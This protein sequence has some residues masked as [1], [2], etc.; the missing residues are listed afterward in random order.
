MTRI[1]DRTGIG[2]AYGDPIWKP[3]R[4]DILGSLTTELTGYQHKLSAFLGPSS[5]SISFM[6]TPHDVDTWAID[7]L[8]RTVYATDHYQVGIWEGFVNEIFLNRGGVQIKIGPLLEIGNRIR[9]VYEE[10]DPATMPPTSLGR[11]ETTIAED[12]RSQVRYGILEQVISVG[13]VETTVA[14]Q[15]RDAHLKN[16]KS[17]KSSLT[18]NLDENSEPKIELSCLGIGD[19]LDAYIYENLAGSGTQTLSD[20]IKDILAADPNGLFLIKRVQENLFAV[21]EW[22]S[23]YPT[24]LACLKE[25]V[26]VGDASDNRWILYVRPGREI[27]YR[28]IGDQ[29]DYFWSATQNRMTNRAGNEIMPWSVEAGRW[30]RINDFLIGT[31]T[32][33]DIFEDVQAVF[34]ETVNFTAPN[35]ITFEGGY[36]N[37]LAQWLAKFGLGGSYI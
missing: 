23:D 31:T 6:A 35:Q 16:R 3:G 7:G 17:A 1:Y 4:R 2:I 22:E 8:G 32:P 5:C 26:A 25:L 29:V 13:Q 9:A 21:Q 12:G 15:L 11:T 36:V 24:G 37:T 27:V 10:I 19:L 20:R 33:D 34:L 28:P 30:L 18:L 14:E